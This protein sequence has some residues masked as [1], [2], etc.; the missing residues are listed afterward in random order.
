MLKYI[1]LLKTNLLHGSISHEINAVLLY[2]VISIS[3]WYRDKHDFKSQQIHEHCGTT[4]NICIL[5]KD[6]QQINKPVWN[7]CLAAVLNFIFC[8]SHCF[9]KGCFSSKTESCH[10]QLLGH[11]FLQLRKKK[12]S[13]QIYLLIIRDLDLSPELIHRRPASLSEWRNYASQMTLDPNHASSDPGLPW[14]QLCWAGAAPYG[15]KVLCREG[16]SWWLKITF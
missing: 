15:A 13:E 14:L 5:Q 7:G 8:T 2:L 12:Q 4:Q 9:L 6:N 11:C 3:Y 10:D 1:K 16:V